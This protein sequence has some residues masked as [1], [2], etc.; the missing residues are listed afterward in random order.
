MEKKLKLFSVLTTDRPLVFSSIVITEAIV[1]DV[2][3]TIVI[4]EPWLQGYYRTCYIKLID[5]AS[6]RCPELFGIHVI[7]VRQVETLS[8]IFIDMLL[9]EAMKKRERNARRATVRDA[10]FIYNRGGVRARCA[11]SGRNARVEYYARLLRLSS[12]AC[13]SRRAHWRGASRSRS[14]RNGKQW[15]NHCLLSYRDWLN[16]RIPS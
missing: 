7:L 13:V 10:R 2:T 3:I 4:A 1:R 6:G 12:L 16:L 9:H 8:S 14:R 15:R 11:A 5:L